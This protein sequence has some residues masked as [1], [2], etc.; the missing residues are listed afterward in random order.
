MNWENTDDDWLQFTGAANER[1]DNLSGRQLTG[2][3]QDTFGATN[4]EDDTQREF[5]DWQQRLR[6]IERTAH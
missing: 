1:W 5:T 3:I 6:E 4:L 2:R